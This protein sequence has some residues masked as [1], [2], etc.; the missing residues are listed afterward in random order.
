MQKH[1]YILKQEQ[2]NAEL[3]FAFR[4]IDQIFVKYKLSPLFFFNL[5]PYYET[6]K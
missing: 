1:C 4:N 2:K 3:L 6:T 5:N